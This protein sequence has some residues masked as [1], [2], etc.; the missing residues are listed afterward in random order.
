MAS[1]DVMRLRLSTPEFSEQL[2]VQAAK[3]ASA[4][5][6]EAE[7]VPLHANRLDW[8]R[9]TLA[10]PT[11]GLDLVIWAVVSNPA[12]TA[13]AASPETI[14]DAEVETA[15]AAVLNGF[16]SPIDPIASKPLP[17]VRG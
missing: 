5:L 15:I 9:K 12:I 2:Q 7:T 16:L 8:A 14:E 4:I 11:Y 3:V 17:V 10:N 13:K 6:T 1:A